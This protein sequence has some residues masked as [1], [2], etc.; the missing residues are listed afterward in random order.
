[1][2]DYAVEILQ[3]FQS[4]MENF[5]Y[6]HL[7]KKTGAEKSTFARK[8]RL[9][10]SAIQFNVLSVFLN[11]KLDAC[12]LKTSITCVENGILV[13]PKISFA[14][15]FFEEHPNGCDALSPWRLVE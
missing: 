10:L 14:P 7:L 5:V 3:T 13:N 15:A 8:R 2:V 4:K 6:Y 12:Y 11:R 9:R 1:M